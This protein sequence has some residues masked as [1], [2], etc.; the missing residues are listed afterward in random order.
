MLL[1]ILT[2]VVA[3]IAAGAPASGDESRSSGSSKS[4]QA[5]AAD[6]TEPL[7][8]LT[9]DN[10]LAVSNR[11]GTGVAHQL[12]VQPVIPLPPFERFPVGQIIRPSIP[13]ITTPGPDRVTGLGDITLFDIFLPRRF[14]WGALGAGPVFVFPSATDDRLGQGK[15][16]LGPASVLIYEAIPH[17]QLGMILQ[18]PIS[19]AGDGDRPGVNSLQVQPI[20]QYN[21]PSGWYVSVGDFTWSFD[22]KNGGKATIPLALQAGRVMPIFGQQWNLGLEP[23]YVVAHD[24]PSPR[25]GFR[26]GISLLLPER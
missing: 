11:G 9:I 3:V 20:A 5:K 4:L 2:G 26:F 13:V 16:Q 19:F 25:W 6:P 10:D 8:Q 12:L 18:N 17:L 1:W 24:G 15:W 22:W 14:S 23:F 21:L 7:V